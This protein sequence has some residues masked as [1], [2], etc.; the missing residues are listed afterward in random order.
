MVNLFVISNE[1]QGEILTAKPTKRT[2]KI[3]HY[4]RD[5]MWAILVYL[6]D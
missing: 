5:D 3:S 2:F 6:G 4:V 1:V